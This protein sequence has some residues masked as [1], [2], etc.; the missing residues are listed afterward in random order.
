MP[1]GSNEKRESGMGFRFRKSINLGGGFKIN[2]SKSGIGYSFGTKGYRVTKKA[3]GGTRS[4]L[5]VPGTGISYV[6]ETNG[7]SRNHANVGN[8]SNYN[9]QP[10]SQNNGCDNNHYDTVAISNG[11]AENVVS[12]GL[13]EMI[14]LANKS[15]KFNNWSTIGIIVSL[16]L[17]CSNP[18]FILLV[19]VCVACKIYIHQNG[20][21]NL[22]YTIDDEQRSIINERM[23][24]MKKIAQ[25]KKI[26]SITQ[27]SKV[28]DS[29]YTGGANTTVKRIPCTPTTKLPFPF[30]SNEEALCF[31][32]SKEKLIF[33]PDKFF[34]IKN[35]KIGALNYS[36]L[37]STVSATRF[38][39]SE[40]VPSDAKVVDKTWKYVNKSGGP[41]KRFSDNRQYPVCLYGELTLRAAEGNIN[42]ILMFSNTDIE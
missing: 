33:L 41:D 12:E 15:Y 4:T 9:R 38:V 13:E 31:Q 27:S 18:I 8:N 24:P 40:I 30:T 14:A 17:S 23:N 28:I 10:D 3:S 32:Y 2:L 19:C 35:G 16:V 11:K 7:K 25:S 22:D 29:K 1:T 6:H 42:T 36:D 34:I 5:S 21:I 37:K 26:W 39:E 20:K